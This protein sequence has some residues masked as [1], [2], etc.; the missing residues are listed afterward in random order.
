MLMTE[1][2]F[3]YNYAKLYHQYN[4]KAVLM[5]ENWTDKDCDAKYAK[6]MQEYIRVKSVSEEKNLSDNK[7]Q[8][9]LEKIKKDRLNHTYE[10]LFDDVIERLKSIKGALSPQ[11]LAAITS[12]LDRYR[13][14]HDANFE[15]IYE[16]RKF[17]E[18]EY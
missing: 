13:S 4:V 8:A 2:D 9:F 15:F 17:E 11:K 16:L 10:I 1:A 5:I 7:I 12:R 18:E 3:L 14:L 6:Y